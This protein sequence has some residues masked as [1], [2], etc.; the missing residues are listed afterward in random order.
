MLC[1]KFSVILCFI[2]FVLIMDD[3]EWYVEIS[4][5]YFGWI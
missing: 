4:G 1:I 2:V 5:V 3:G